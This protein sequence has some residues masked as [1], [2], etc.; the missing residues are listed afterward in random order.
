MTF[1]FKLSDT[2][3]LQRAFS[4]GGTALNAYTLDATTGAFAVAGVA[5]QVERSLLL[6]A[7]IG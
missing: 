1:S 7:A 2:F 5:A 6:N 4:R 3:R